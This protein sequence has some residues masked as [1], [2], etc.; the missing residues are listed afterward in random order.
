MAVGRRKHINGIPRKSR[1]ITGLSCLSWSATNGGLGVCPAFSGSPRWSSGPPEKGEKGRKR[2]EKA[3]FRPISRKGGQTPFKPP[4]VTPLFAAAQLSLSPRKH[5]RM[6]MLP[7]KSFSAVLCRTIAEVT[8]KRIHAAIRNFP[9]TPLG[10]P[11]TFSR[12]LLCTWE[13]YC[14]ANGRRTPVQMGGVLL[15]FPFLKA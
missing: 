10:P 1:I 13:A 3:D 14:S 7:R 12:A 4:F 5:Y 9:V 11:S 15:G 8:S 2:A 6:E